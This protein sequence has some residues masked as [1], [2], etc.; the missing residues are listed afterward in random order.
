M[1]LRHIAAAFA[2]VLILAGSTA[3]AADAAVLR[4]VAKVSAKVVAKGA[5][6]VAKAAK[7]VGKAAVKTVKFLF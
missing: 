3:P 1:R 2:A 4:T 7:A 5:V 6:G